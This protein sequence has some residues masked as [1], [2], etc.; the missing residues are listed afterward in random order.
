MTARDRVGVQDFVLLEEF[1]SEDAFI[2]N[3]KKRFH[4]KLIYVSLRLHI[5]IN[6]GLLF[7]D[8][9]TKLIMLCYV[10]YGMFFIIIFLFNRH[11]LVRF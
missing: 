4:E 5:I 3:L 9:V 11:I 2:E 8:N 1:R 7:L 6:T 10:I